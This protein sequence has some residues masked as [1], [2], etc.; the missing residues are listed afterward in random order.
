MNQLEQIAQGISETFAPCCEVVVHD[1][2]A[3]LYN[4]VKV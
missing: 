3:T 1:L 2:R 4:D